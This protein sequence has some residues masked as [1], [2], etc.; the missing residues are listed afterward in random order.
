MVL[1][2]MRMFGNRVALRLHVG[3]ILAQPA[4]FCV[5][6]G[7]LAGIDAEIGLGVSN[8]VRVFGELPECVRQ[9]GFGAVR[10]C[11]GLEQRLHLPRKLTIKRADPALGPSHQLVPGIAV[12]FSFP[13]QNA[14]EIII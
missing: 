7:E 12:V 9:L 3:Q 6:Y 10:S 1:L 14:Q 2:L 5:L 11:C 8:R 4:D 13:G